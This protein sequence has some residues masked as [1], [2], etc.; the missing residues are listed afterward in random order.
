MKFQIHPYNG[1]V[2]TFLVSQFPPSDKLI[3]FY[4]KSMHTTHY[5]FFVTVVISQIIQPAGQLFFSDG[6]NL[7]VSK[8]K[9][10]R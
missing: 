1:E 5:T 2:H 9:G 3:T 10:Y 8:S 6:M 4:C 7:P